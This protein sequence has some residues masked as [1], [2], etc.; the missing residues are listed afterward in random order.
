MSAPLH[1]LVVDDRPDSVLFLTEFLISRKHRVSTVGNGKDALQ[2]I[3]RRRA[4]NDGYDL[5]I[6][7]VS[8]P[9]M[10]GLSLLKELRR[11]QETVELAICTAYAAMHANL[12]QEAERLGCL[13]VLEKPADMLALD[14]LM[15][16]VSSR[17]R[18]SPGT[19]KSEQ[20]FF[21][22]SRV[23]RA[24]DVKT[25]PIRREPGTAGPG[26]ERRQPGTGHERADRGEPGS[27]HHRRTQ[28]PGSYEP[29][30]R[31]PSPLPFDDEPSPQQQQQPTAPPAPPARRQVSFSHAAPSE[32]PPMAQPAPGQP[33]T[34]RAIRPPA[35][36]PLPAD[37][38]MPPAP[39]TD[40]TNRPRPALP[41]A[42]EAVAVPKPGEAVDPSKLSPVTTRLR[43]TVTGTERIVRQPPPMAGAAD[44]SRPVGCAVCGKPFMVADKPAAYSVVCMHCGQLNRIEP[45]SPPPAA[46]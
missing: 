22:T 38:P 45:L 41:L 21:G 42:P 28:Q 1:I 43:R 31:Y 35:A 6:C 20:P 19:T 10:D 2:A 32:Q 29:S 26:L 8:V 13:M 37:T 5:V 40:R 33:G 16:L 24:E 12:A 4:G 11:R 34:D 15:T 44:V 46:P 30:T 23:V 9:G 7:E 3:V 14:R 36:V 39:G 18:T 17:K 25:G 27:D